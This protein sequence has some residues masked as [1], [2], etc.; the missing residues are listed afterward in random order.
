MSFLK[1]LKEDWK[2]GVIGLIVVA[3]FTFG[4]DIFNLTKAGAD[5]EF[6]AKIDSRIEEK[7]NDASFVQM[8][9]KSDKVSEFTEDAGKEIRANIIKDVMRKDTN[10]VSFRAVLGQGTG[11]RDEDVPGVIIDLINDYKEGKLECKERDRHVLRG[12]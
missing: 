3:S 7:I 9:L 4:K 5:V 10:K 1:E 2:K 11:L 12:I 8:I 6:N